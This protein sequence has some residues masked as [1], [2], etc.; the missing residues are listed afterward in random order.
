MRAIDL[1]ADLGETVDG[2]PT[3]DDTALF[4]VITS[5]SVAC[6][7]HA[8]DAASMRA[9]AAAAAAG[10]VAV[11]AHPSFPDPA[12][13]GR[14]HLSVDPVLLR[15]QVT[16]QLDAL[17]A[18]GADI[19]YVKP[20]GALYHAV[21]ADAAAAAAVAASVAD[22]SARLGRAVPVLGLDGEIV[23]AVAAAGLGFVREAFLDRAYLPDGTL[24]ARGVPG[25]V[26]HD[27]G[28][29]ADRA[30]RLA[31]DGVVVAVDGALVQTD[32][33]SL[34]VHGDSPGAVAMARAVR[35]ALVAAGVTVRAP[36]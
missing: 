28:E 4:A 32:A 3:A 2:V 20:H 12:N 13:F 9:A 15:A 11:G 22:L 31:V 26:L 14:V 5:A 7:G 1:N 18:A 24:V 34:C 23:A 17:A 19:R 36:W 33:A 16:G 21:S 27:A 35:A 25:A 6:G 29:V 10:A 30:V 8:G